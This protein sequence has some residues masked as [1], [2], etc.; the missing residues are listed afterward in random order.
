MLWSQMNSAGTKHETYFFV[1]LHLR[2]DF[3]IIHIVGTTVLR[4]LKILVPVA[5]Q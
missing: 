5:S 3:L 2:S 1:N 4:M